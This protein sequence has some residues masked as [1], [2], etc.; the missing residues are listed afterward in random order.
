MT[1]E[2][3]LRSLP[4]L[5]ASSAHAH[6]YVMQSKTRLIDEQTLPRDQ[7]ITRGFVGYGLFVKRK[8][9]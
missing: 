3:D 6:S 8:T 2:E 1:S 9:I 7:F 5:N 4:I